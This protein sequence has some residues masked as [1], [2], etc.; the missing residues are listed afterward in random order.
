MPLGGRL[1]ALL[2]L[3]GL[4][5]RGSRGRVLCVFGRNLDPF[6]RG[7]EGESGLFQV[8]HGHRAGR[9]GHQLAR[10]RLTELVRSGQ[11]NGRYPSLLVE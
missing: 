1:L 6:L 8:L 10:T 7:R 3:G 9:R 11:S 4:R 2:R 5:G